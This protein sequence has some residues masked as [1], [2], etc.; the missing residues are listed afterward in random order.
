MGKNKI[1]YDLERKPFVGEFKFGSWTFSLVSIHLICATGKKKDMK[2]E[3]NEQECRILPTIATIA[4]ITQEQDVILLGDFNCIPPARILKKVGYVSLF[5]E[6][7]YTNTV[8]NKC[9]D[10]ILIHSS[11]SISHYDTHGVAD[12][13]VGTEGDPRIILQK[14]KDVSDHCPIFADFAIKEQIL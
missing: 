1:E 8:N 7:E 12:I 10:N 6:N 11:L 4:K 13:E 2:K 3:K 5:R 14:K 9:F